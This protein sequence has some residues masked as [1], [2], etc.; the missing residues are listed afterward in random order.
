MGEPILN[1]A[2]AFTT[3]PEIRHLVGQ[4]S[5]FDIRDAL[6]RGQWIVLQLNKSELGE[7]SETLA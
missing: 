6:D 4:Q 3:D 5:T 7:N 2:S 1:K